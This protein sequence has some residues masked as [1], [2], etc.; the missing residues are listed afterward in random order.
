L[1]GHDVTL[2]QIFEVARNITASYA[3]AGYALSFA[4]V[5]AQEIDKAAGV[6]RIDV[7]EGYVGDIRFEGGP[8]T[9]PDVV[10]SFGDR[11]KNSRPLKTAIL[12]RLLLLMNDLPGY[13]ANA[14]FDRIVDGPKGATRLVVKLMHQPV[15]AA[16]EVD[17]RGSKAFGPWQTSANLTLNSLLGQ[18]E[19]IMLRG[20]RALNSNQLSAGIAKVSAPIGS[21]GLTLSLTGTYSDAHPGSAALST[22]NF[23]SSGWTVSG[24][25]NYPLL[26][27]RAQSVWIWAG[28]GGKWLHSDLLSAPNS[29][30]HIYAVQAGATW[31]E[32]GAEG[33][34]AADATLSQGLKI[35]DATTASSLLRSRQAG[36][37]VYTSLNA[38]L[39]RLQQVTQTSSGE[40]DLFAAVSGQ[41]ASRGLLAPE[42]C[43]YGGAEFGRGFDSNEIVGDHCVMGS[44]ELRFAPVLGERFAALNQAQ[45]FAVA[46][47][48]E[49]WNSGTLGFGDKRSEGGA[50]V[51]AGLRFQL[52]THVNASIEYD[53]PVGRPVALEGN[54]NE[55]IFIQL[56]IQN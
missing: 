5:P 3:Q 27:S 9:L 26:R 39:T 44:V 41:I 10:Q 28:A 4:L 34:T 22:L 18:G 55:R 48:G 19:A 51:G 23:T 54:R 25:L 8:P 43:G 29:R 17:N 49:V 12:E 30:D 35:F 21:N 32:R 16:A 56:G 13:S 33:V 11:I 52:I 31:N 53:Q 40:V 24:Q 38:N 15:L 20:L 45:I 37:G 1:I 2:A 36:N 7:V 47:A 6:A 50:S 46:D 42:Q 14:V